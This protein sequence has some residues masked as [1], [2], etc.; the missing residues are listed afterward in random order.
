L[1]EA[2]GAGGR[3]GAGAVD[4][5]DGTV[6]VSQRNPFPGQPTQWEIV[7]TMPICG[8]EAV[9][10]T[11]QA[12]GPDSPPPVVFGPYPPTGGGVYARNLALQAGAAATV[13]LPVIR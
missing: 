13:H 7:R 3:I 10:V 5:A 11:L 12:I 4:A 2:A 9:R 8:G 1:V 6:L